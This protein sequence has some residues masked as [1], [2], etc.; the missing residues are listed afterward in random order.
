MSK[1]EE[2]RKKLENI[3]RYFM[4][5]RIVILYKLIINYNQIKY[6]IN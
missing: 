5:E 1:K 6:A 2:Q 4:S 3:I